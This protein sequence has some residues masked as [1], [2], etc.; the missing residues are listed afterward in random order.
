MNYCMNFKM[1][2]IKAALFIFWGLFFLQKNPSWAFIII[3]VGAIFLIFDLADIAAKCEEKNKKDPNS[4]TDS[5][6][7]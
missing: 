7:Y 4:K 2:F 6:I 1:K 5:S 3:I